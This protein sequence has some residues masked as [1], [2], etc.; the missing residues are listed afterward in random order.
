MDLRALDTKGQPVAVDH[1]NGL[2]AIR[3][4]VAARAPELALD[5]DLAVG[6]AGGDDLSDR[7]DQGFDADLGATALR[8]PDPEEG[9]PDLDDRGDADEDEA[10]RLRDDEDGEDDCDDEEHDLHPKEPSR[11]RAGPRIILAG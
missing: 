2:A 7:A 6:S 5:A 1:A 8:E 4:L 3:A 9:L 11:E 10:P